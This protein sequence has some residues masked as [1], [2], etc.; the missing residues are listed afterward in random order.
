M[1]K[2]SRD[3]ESKRRPHG[4]LINLTKVVE[5]MPHLPYLPDFVP[6]DFHL[7]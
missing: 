1:N 5:V 4:T 3:I 2:K 6:S 7:L